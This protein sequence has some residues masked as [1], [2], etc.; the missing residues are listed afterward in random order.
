MILRFLF[1]QLDLSWWKS[2][3]PALAAVVLYRQAVSKHQTYLYPFLDRISLN[4]EVLRED[5]S[6]VFPGHFLAITAIYFITFSH[7][8]MLWE[9]LISWF[10]NHRL[11]SMRLYSNSSLNSKGVLY[12]LSVRMTQQAYCTCHSS[13][14]DSR[15]NC[16]VHTSRHLSIMTSVLIEKYKFVFFLLVL[17]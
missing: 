8:E 5:T 1:W 7:Y 13:M 17:L 4:V 2:P 11:N 15:V 14:Y 6:K 16:N 12:V 3:S 9:I 10:C